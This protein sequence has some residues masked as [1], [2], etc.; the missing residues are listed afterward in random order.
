MSKQFLKNLFIYTL[1]LVIGSSCSKFNKL[2]KSSDWKEKYDAALM[3]YDKKDYYRANVLIEEVL[4]IIRGSE[5]AEKAQYYFANSFFFQKQYSM[6]AHHFKTFYT[7]FSRSQWAEESMYMYAYSTYLES[8][9]HNL[10]QTNTYEA[11]QAMQNFINRY[12]YSSYKEKATDIIN[13]L[14]T[15]L[16]DK[17]YEQAKLYFKLRR[18]KSALIAFDN[19]KNDYPDSRLKEEVSYLEIDT[20]YNYAK[21]SI[22]SKQ[23]ERYNTVIQ[24]YQNFVDAYPNSKY[25][26][27]AQSYYDG[28][29]KE[30]EKLNSQTQLLSNNQ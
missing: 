21:E 15:K 18:Y 24:L 28:A 11:I 25:I 3:Y 22:Y 7:T 2:R 17:A 19:F 9:I 13:S 1:I 5:E 30:I 26:K 8:P 23:K 6:S 12:P 14:Q 10:D 20:E 29:L 16:E 27:D 4:P